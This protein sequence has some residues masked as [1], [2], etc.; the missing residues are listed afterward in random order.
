MYFN[1]LTLNSKKFLVTGASSGLGRATSVILSK[2]G[3][4]LILWDIEE[5]GLMTTKE[6]CG[7]S[8]IITVISDLQNISEIKTNLFKSVEKLGKLNG[9][10]HLAG[11]PCI[12]PL[13][14]IKHE[15]INNVFNL[16]TYSALELSKNFA[17]KNVYDGNSG[18]IVFIS[19]IYG[20]VGSVANVGYAMSKSALHGITKSLAIELAPKKIR[21][22]CIAPGFVKTSMLDSISTLFDQEYFEKINKLHPLGLGEAEDVANLIAFLFSDMSKWITGSIINIDGGYTAQ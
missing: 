1:P 20:L 16:N 6:M 7:E 5:R 2:L 4:E 18:S 14:N 3:A 17:T 19:S 11:I 21:V 9:L 8:K 12:S 10:V 15:N 13:K 22:N